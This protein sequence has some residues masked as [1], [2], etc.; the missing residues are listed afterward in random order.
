MQETLIFIYCQCSKLQDKINHSDDSFYKILYINIRTLQ[1]WSRFQQ[2]T[3]KILA[4]CSHFMLVLAVSTHDMATR[5]K[6]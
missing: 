4:D 3:M 2:I 6:A 1:R 5:Y